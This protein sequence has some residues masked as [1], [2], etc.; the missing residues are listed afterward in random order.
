MAIGLLYIAF[1]VFR[2]GL[3]IPALSKT[4]IMKGCWILSNTF[5][6]PVRWFSGF[7]F[8][9]QFVYMVDYVDGLSYIE[10]LLHSW[11]KAYLIMVDCVFDVFLDL[12]CKYFI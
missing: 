3:G 12:V 6:H 5:Q 8:S 11:G 10:P 1:M 4:F 2:Y 9:F 7:F